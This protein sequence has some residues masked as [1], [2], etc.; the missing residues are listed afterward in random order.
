MIAQCMQLCMQ[1]GMSNL[2]ICVILFANQ[3]VK[4][5]LASP[6]GFE[7]S[8]HTALPSSTGAAFSVESNTN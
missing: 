6:R 4:V 3:P 1:N 7:V 5:G 2:L 8:P